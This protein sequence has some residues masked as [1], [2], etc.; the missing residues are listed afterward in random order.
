MSMKVKTSTASAARLFLYDGITTT[1][2]SYHTGGGAF[3]KL[4]VTTAIASAGTQ[5]LIGIEFNAS[6]TIYLD[7]AALCIGDVGT[8]YS[9]LTPAEELA[10]CHRY[11]QVLGGVTGGYPQVGG[12][13]AS[14][15]KNYQLS[16]PWHEKMVTT[17]TVTIE[18]TWAVSNCGQPSSANPSV[19]GFKL[20]VAASG[21][22]DF[23]AHPDSSDDLVKAEANP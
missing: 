8:D 19:S 7:N 5:L 23:Y 2:G 1:Y 22:G 14:G 15:A 17:P 12:A 6:A 16:H 20:Q 18:G 13:Y 9:P 11:Y 3:E 21:A 10:I 4:T